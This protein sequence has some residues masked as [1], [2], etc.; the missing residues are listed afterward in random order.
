MLILT[1]ANHPKA[2]SQAF[3]RDFNPQT[4][5]E[6]HPLI[7]PTIS[8]GNQLIN[9]LTVQKGVVMGLKPQL[10]SMLE[11]QLIEDAQP[12]EYANHHS[13][14]APLSTA[15]IHW[16]IFCHLEQQ[17]ALVQQQPQ[18][19]L[20]PLLSPLLQHTTPQQRQRRLWSLSAEFARYQSAYLHQR[21]DWL[22]QWQHTPPPLPE[23][24]PF[25]PPQDY[26]QWLQ[27]ED[28]ASYRAQVFLYQTLLLE[29]HQHRQAKE[30]HF[31]KHL[32][33]H[34]SLPKHLWIYLLD[35]A[36][37]RMLDFLVRLGKQSACQVHLYHYSASEQYVADLVDAQWLAQHNDE[38]A[39]YDSGNYLFSR[40]GKLQ[41]STA[42]ALQQHQLEA[43]RTLHLQPSPQTL[44]QTLKNAINR[45]DDDLNAAP[46]FNPIQPDDSL[47]IHACHGLLRQLEV[48]RH[49]LVLWLNADKTRKLSDI[50]I[51]APNVSNISASLHAIF[52][53]SGQ[54]DGYT[55]PARIT[56]VLN[57]DD[58]RLWQSLRGQF[59]LDE[60]L[61]LPTLAEWLN[62][63]ETSTALGL[64]HEQTQRALQLLQQAGFRRA[65]DESA[66]R[67]QLVADDDDTRHCFTHAL[68]RILSGMLMPQS[69]LHAPLEAV[70]LQDRVIVEA[71]CR[72]AEQWL[73]YRAERPTKQARD[74]LSEIRQAL[75][76]Q[77]Q[78]YRH[79]A[80]Y[81][82]LDHILRDLHYTLNN[83][84]TP[85]H[86]A[87][88]LPFLLE[89]VDEH[90]AQKNTGGEP[91]G[92]ITIGQLSAMRSIPYKLIAFI[93]ADQSAFPSHLQEERH[94]LLSLDRPRHLD[95][96]RQHNDM[97]AFL[98]T[99]LYA[100]Q[101]AWY[102]YSHTD[103]QHHEEQ[104][105]CFPVQ[106][107]LDYLRR[108]RPDLEAQYFI[109]HPQ[110]PLDDTHSA[111]LWRALH[112]VKPQ[113]HQAMVTLSHQAQSLKPL[114]QALSLKTLNHQLLRPAS[115][116]LK[117]R[118]IAHLDEEPIRFEALEPLSLSP[119]NQTHLRKR[120]IQSLDLNPNTFPEL[121]VGIIGKTLLQ[122]EQSALRERIEAFLNEH[123]AKALSETQEQEVRLSFGTLRA[124]LPIHQHEA[125]LTLSASRNHVKHRLWHWLHHLLWQS[126]GANQPTIVSFVQNTLTFPPLSRDEAED[127]LARYIALWQQNSQIHSQDT[128]EQSALSPI[129][130]TPAFFELISITTDLPKALSSWLQHLF[131]PQTYLT[132]PYPIDSHAALRY[133]LQHQ[134]ALHDKLLTTTQFYQH[135][136]D[137][138]PFQP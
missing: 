116:F 20:Y 22:Q 34:P 2:L 30:A 95:Y 106:E 7:T 126:M 12:P 128:S 136:F 111:P 27:Q 50:L 38:D 8:I 5:F 101:S 88:H 21:P 130:F 89:Y 100:E 55:L 18:H 104:A 59:V 25:Y 46:V 33:Q 135:H 58:E 134:S 28:E 56:G 48:L 90:L 118:Q 14:F 129:L 42:R 102:F 75:E 69:A 43:E 81:A 108:H 64:S 40:F 110:D 122:Q 13:E 121:P 16:K 19:P 96:N 52:P 125:W 79:H 78:A 94:L 4:P 10:W 60:Q 36:S 70:S 53:R 127:E 131:A 133:L 32:H 83:P 1:Q 73:R 45:L 9:E 103:P 11:W 49:R 77:Y 29:D 107:L 124:S 3:I 57:S 6:Y 51:V 24:L 72:L 61:D 92:V 80:G 120:L 112:E 138:T 117:Q 74:W 76:S 137:L 23:L 93:Q 132:Q 37:P 26:P 66:L 113:A 84:F 41:R 91:S 85:E 62:L 109:Q 87:L 39:H 35:Q 123:H 98:S 15:S 67:E 99:L 105:P 115:A 54:Y 44:L 82:H 114:N 65:L 68:D 119:K 31:W 47:Q 17:S 86:Q 63:P 71:L 97:N